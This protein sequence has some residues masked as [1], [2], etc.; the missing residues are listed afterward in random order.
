MPFVKPEFLQIIQ[1]FYNVH[2]SQSINIEYKRTHTTS[3][4]AEVRTAIA[5][6][7]LGSRVSPN[8][9]AYWVPAVTSFLQNWMQ[10]AQ[11]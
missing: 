1:M 7:H 11:P 10:T 2:F 8:S 3:L 9:I 4:H 5:L 6:C